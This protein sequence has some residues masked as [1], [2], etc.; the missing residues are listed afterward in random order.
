MAECHEMIAQMINEAGAK[1][2][3]AATLKSVR[4]GKGANTEKFYLH[5]SRLPCKEQQSCS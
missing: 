2:V 3:I 1:K 5:N 4:L